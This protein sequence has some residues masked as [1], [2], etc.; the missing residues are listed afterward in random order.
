[1]AVQSGQT[2][3]TNGPYRLVRHP[4]YTGALITFVAGCILL[5]SW[6]A[7]A[8]TAFALTLAFVRRIGYEET[9]LI[10]TLPGYGAY[11]SGTGRL[12]PRII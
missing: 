12:L 10:R 1:V 9:L 4:S 5:R 2:L 3:V 6:I 8:L 11:L 7:A